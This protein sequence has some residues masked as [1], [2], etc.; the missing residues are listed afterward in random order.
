MISSSFL[1]IS[2]SI[3]SNEYPEYRGQ[4]NNYVVT[5]EHFTPL[6][7][8]LVAHGQSAAEAGLVTRARKIVASDNVV[9]H[10]TSIFSPPQDNVVRLMDACSDEGTIVGIHCVLR[11]NQNGLC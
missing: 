5:G 4:V 3:D 8:W 10:L 1:L 2:S 7:E 6:E 9:A 11:K